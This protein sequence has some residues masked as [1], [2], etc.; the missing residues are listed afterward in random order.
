MATLMLSVSVWENSPYDKNFMLDK[1][2]LVV[3]ITNT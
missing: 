1:L 2:Q 3:Q